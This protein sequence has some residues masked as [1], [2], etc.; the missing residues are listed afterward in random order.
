MD[1]TI[2]SKHTVGNNSNLLVGDGNS[3]LNYEPFQS[4]ILYDVC[5]AVMEAD[6]DLTPEDEYSLHTNSNWMKKFDYNK[7]VK[8]VD[9]FNDEAPDI[10]R[11]E[12]IMESFA[13]NRTLLINKIKH[14]YRIIE[15]E[16]TK[17]NEDGDFVL[18]GVFKELCKVVDE[19]G[20]PLDKQIPMEQKER[21]IKLIMFYA[22]TKCQLLKPVGE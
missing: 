15:K 6:I 22:F 7:V 16:R 5:R 13:N 14:V 1:K 17:A 20:R 18:E 4:S 19:S 12:E 3:I 2:P 11:L 21:Y 10:D 8:F 9:I